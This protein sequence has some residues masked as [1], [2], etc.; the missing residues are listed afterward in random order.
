MTSLAGLASLASTF[1]KENSILEFH[2]RVSSIGQQQVDFIGL[3]SFAHIGDIVTLGNPHQSQLGEI[4]KVS[5]KSSTATLLKTQTNLKVGDPVR[6]GGPL[7]LWPSSAWLGRVI[8]SFGSPIDGRGS[9][10][11]GDKSYLP[12]CN[13]L[14]PMVR[15]R[16]GRRVATGVR[17]I[18]IFSPVCEGQRIGLFA[19]SGVGKSTLLGMIS[20]SLDFDVTVVA[21]VG[22]RSRE[23]LEFIEDIIGSRM[24]RTVVVV[25][26]S[27]ETP[28][29]RRL[30]P[31]T[32]TAVAEFFRDRG[33]SVCLVIDSIARFAH[34][35]RDIAISSGELP[36]AR[37]FPPSVLNAIARLLERSGPGSNASGSIT[38]F[39]TV[40][41]DG[42]D[43]NDPIS[44]HIRG[45]LD[46]H[47][48]LSRTIAEK[49]RYPAIDL[50]KSISRLATS[51][52]SADEARLVRYLREF[53]SIY[54]DS[55]DL[56][57]IGGYVPGRN[58]E[59]DQAVTLVPRLYE[60]ITQSSPDDKWR[61]Q[62]AGLSQM[63]TSI[64]QPQA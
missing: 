22:E 3:S 25:S 51:L 8:N 2:G 14:P 13:P 50:L 53:V 27:D 20:R 5:Q 62:Y 23:V 44:D 54:E 52:W 61:D 19:G 11:N 33:M 15:N 45:T 43:H 12:D 28:M 58:I 38:A 1:A 29:V 9:L 49:G 48:V 55:H 46:G 24:N 10:A 39:Y 17:A 32:A 7:Q 31:R 4:V 60:Y 59:L 6:L 18:D 41:V 36:I 64:K 37:G 56:R 63:I 26:T 21:L 34:A 40:L 47:I 42:D 30:A 57:L 16:V 35:L